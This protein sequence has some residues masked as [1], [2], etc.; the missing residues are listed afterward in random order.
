MLSPQEEIAF[1]GVLS[2]SQAGPYFV[3]MEV[4]GVDDQGYAFQRTVEKVS[5]GFGLICNS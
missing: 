2:A 5:F 3:T 4:K 1:Q